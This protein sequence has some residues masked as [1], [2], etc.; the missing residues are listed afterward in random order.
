MLVTPFTK[1]QDGYYLFADDEGL[2]TG[3]TTDVS[4][5]DTCKGELVGIHKLSNS[6]YK[7]MYDWYGNIW[8][9]QPK[10]GYEYALLEMSKQTEKIYVLKEEHLFWYEIDDEAD[11]LYAEKNVISHINYIEH[12]KNRIF[13]YDRGYHSSGSHQHHQG[14]RQIWRS[15]RWFV[16]R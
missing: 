4:K 10:L 2:L 3:C 11:L 5:R 1:Q 16:D 15:C 13:R 8:R 9:Q 6:T 14:S 7:K 12:E